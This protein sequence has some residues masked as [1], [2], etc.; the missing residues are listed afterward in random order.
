MGI[1]EFFKYFKLNS[2][3]TRK[4]NC[5]LELDVNSWVKRYRKD[6]IRKGWVKRY[7][8]EDYDFTLSRR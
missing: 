7:R 5:G 2:Y 8:K 1:L 6:L 3:G 4:Y